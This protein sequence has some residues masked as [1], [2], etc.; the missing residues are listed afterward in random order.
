M[1]QRHIQSVLMVSAAFFA[2]NA[3]VGGARANNATPFGASSVAQVAQVRVQS[4]QAGAQK[5]RES[6]SSDDETAG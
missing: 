1:K 6:E 2:I 3:P 5:R 4:V